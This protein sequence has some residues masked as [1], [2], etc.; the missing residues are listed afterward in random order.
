MENI[1]VSSKIGEQLRH[2][3]YHAKKIAE[4]KNGNNPSINSYKYQL[5]QTDFGIYLMFHLT[6]FYGLNK[7]IYTS[8]LAQTHSW[9]LCILSRYTLYIYMYCICIYLPLLCFSQVWLP[10]LYSKVQRDEMPDELIIYIPQRIS[11]QCLH[12][13]QKEFVQL[14]TCKLNTPLS[15]QKVKQSCIVSG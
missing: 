7:L 3:G 1:S 13:L 15:G 9:L 12:T 2:N 11:L 5:Q 14:A 6:V 4:R 10:V 8:D